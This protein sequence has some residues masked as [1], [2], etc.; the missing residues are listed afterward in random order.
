MLVELVAAEDQRGGAAV[1]AVLG[2]VDQVPLLDQ[3]GDLFRRQAVAGLA[4][5]R[6]QPSTLR[7]SMPL[8]GTRHGG[9][10]VEGVSFQANEVIDCVGFEDR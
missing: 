3:G 7:L 2:V 4:G 1:G 10:V 6:V 8:A 9:Q 5:D